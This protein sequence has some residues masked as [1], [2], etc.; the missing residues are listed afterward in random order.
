MKSKIIKILYINLRSTRVFE[1]VEKTTRSS[2][3]V[4]NGTFCG[5]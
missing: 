1:Y 3:K 4:E 2:R 5:K